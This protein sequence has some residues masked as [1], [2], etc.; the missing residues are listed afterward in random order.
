MLNALNSSE[1]SLR[2][3]SGLDD[4]LCSTRFIIASLDTDAAKNKANEKLKAIVKKYTDI[5]NNIKGND[6]LLSNTH[7]KTIENNIR[8]K[9]R[10][11][12]N[13]INSY[14]YE[15]TYLKDYNKDSLLEELKYSQDLA[16]KKAK[17]NIDDYVE[18]HDIVSYTAD[19]LNSIFDCPLDEDGNPL[20]DEENTNDAL[21]DLLKKIK[22]SIK[23]INESKITTIDEY[24]KSMH[25]VLKKL[26]AV[27]FDVYS[28]ISDTVNYRKNIR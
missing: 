3:E 14:G 7:P 1:A 18:K 25:K 19:I 24:N 10:E 16:E 20:M 4:L 8:S 21:N 17:V 11:L 23:M 26:A 13:L 12:L 22:E 5:I 27:K 9:I 15:E 6:D 28:Q 2:L